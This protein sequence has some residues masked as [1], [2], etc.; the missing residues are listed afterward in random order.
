M[1][2]MSGTNNQYI[3]ENTTIAGISY[4]EILKHCRETL[5]TDRKSLLEIQPETI[6][7]DS[8]LFVKPSSLLRFPPVAVCQ[9]GNAIVVTCSCDTPKTTLC[10]HQAQVLCAIMDRP[11]L[12]VFYDEELRKK[13]LRVAAKEYGMEA[14]LNPEHYFQIEYV[15]NSLRIRPKIKELIKL[16][17]EKLEQIEQRLLPKANLETKT[18]ARKSLYENMF[19]VIRKHKY[20][21]YLNIE[22]CEA[23]RTQSGKIK[24]PISPI[25][26]IDLVW[27]TEDIE[28]AKFLTAILKFQN[29]YS[30]ERTDT[31]FDAL[32]MIIRN[33][34]NLEVY[35][36][37]KET[38][39]NIIANSL[40]PVELDILDA[41]V[42]LSVFKKEPFYEITGELVVQQTTYSFETVNIKFGYF[43]QQG[44]K[45]SLV[46][47]EGML[48]LI[49][50]FKANNEIVLLHSSKYEEFRQTI[51]SK[52][53]DKININ[54][55]YIAPATQTQLIEQRHDKKAEKIIYLSDHG[56]YV[57]ITP[58]MKY[59][60]VEVPVFSRRQIL[61][62]DLNGNVFK[63]RRDNAQEIEFTSLLVRQHPEFEGQLQEAEYFYLHKNKFLD[64]NWFLDTFEKWQN[65]KIVI[66]G[67]NELKK[68][69][70][71]TH[72]VVISVNVASGINW[73]NTKLKVTCG[74]QKVSLK[75]LHKSIRNKSKYVQLDDGTNGI[76]PAEWMKKLTAYFQAGEIEGDVLKIPKSNFADIKQ[77]FDKEMLSQEV[78]EE[79]VDY[80]RNFSEVKDIPKVPVPTELKTTLRDYQKEGL[81]W[82]NFLDKFNFGACLAD[83]MGLGKTVQI[84]AF[85]LSQRTRKKHNT[86]LVVVPT[87]LLFNWQI[88]IE[89]FAPSIRVLTHYGANRKKNVSSFNNY[90]VV[91][92]TYG[93]LL[94]DIRFLKEYC[95][96]Y[97]FLDES[98]AIKNPNSERYKAAR[99][100]QSGNKVVLTG[101]PIE[102]NTFD[103]YGQLSF[104]CPGL[105]G[106]RQYFKDIYSTPVDK[107]EDSKR[108]K[109]LQ[110]K[111]K[112][113]ILRR[114]KRQVAHELPEKTEIVIYCEM[115][116][117]QRRIYDVYEEELRNYISI[118]EEED[119]PKSSMHVLTGLTKLR[120][121]CNSPSLLKDEN[122][123]DSAKI[124]VLVEQIEN[125][126]A[127]HKILVFSQFV[128][129]LDLIKKELINKNIPFEYLTGQTKDR[130]TKVKG[131]QENEKVRVFLISLKAG[132]TGLNLT[133]ADYV[134]LV[135]PWWNPAVENQAIDRCYRIGQK[136]NV[137]AVRLICPNTIE[138]KIM[139][140]QKSKKKL[141][142][143]L[144]K[145]DNSVFKSLSK[146]DLMMLLGQT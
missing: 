60:N 28:E 124:D 101:T 62:T 115:G 110:Q 70:L 52:L 86:N 114:T 2:I 113:F 105:L 23:E 9:S 75:Q 29:N 47:D 31:D 1:R 100:L 20:Y 74:K 112:P 83:D 12:R 42:E 98:Q 27:K 116:E 11:D 77:L 73:F 89:N 88:E 131:F 132:G 24:N 45:L 34:L 126:S 140:L 32:R 146:G 90:E 53:E 13:Q 107:F 143:D 46:A 133:Q 108:A 104:A 93:M 87:T 37:N 76:L 26:P 35:S 68:N 63:V 120:Q 85:I 22:L 141:A 127:Q 21:N 81:N 144:I 40:V 145:T 82:L 43:L 19:L 57:Y 55:A 5:D 106:S 25:A 51:L 33:P 67:F 142:N 15:N 17:P 137:I 14:E 129:M 44:N 8:G 121:I 41:G 66:L 97:I 92:T 119:M 49:E 36:H 10:Q 109:E 122:L 3:L 84:I 64:E 123:E 69:R 58:V 138:E 59:G 91:L 95:F 79:L 65:D 135:D 80:A 139:H 99:L 118:K 56:E 96:N 102:N 130:A 61:D 7:V 6:E 125:K 128:S 38:S 16:N 111:I 54:Y 48:R 134:Y 4:T 78:R 136:K 50:F 103:I 117:R 94:S 30:A 39:E 72:K 18:I 71:N